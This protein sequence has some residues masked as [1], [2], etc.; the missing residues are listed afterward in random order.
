MVVANL[1]PNTGRELLKSISYTEPKRGNVVLG[2]IRGRFHASA[3]DLLREST[4]GRVVIGIR[5]TL[6]R[7]W[8]ETLHFARSVLD[9]DPHEQRPLNRE[10]KLEVDELARD[11]RVLRPDGEDAVEGHRIRTT[12]L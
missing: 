8:R 10:A 5:S 2:R 12:M 9:L 3:F 1:T 4:L 11:R 6:E 7:G